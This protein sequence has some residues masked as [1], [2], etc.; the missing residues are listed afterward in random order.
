M[1]MWKSRNKPTKA[2]EQAKYAAGFFTP[3]D[4]PIEIFLTATVHGTITTTYEKI[5]K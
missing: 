3:I 1:S 5:L 4:Q 2:R